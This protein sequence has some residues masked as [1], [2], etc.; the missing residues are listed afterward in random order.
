MTALAARHCQPVH[1]APLAGAA[2]AALLAEVPAWRVVDG[3]LQREFGFDD[4]ARMMGFAN[5]V[6]WLAGRE[7]HHPEIHIAWGRCTVRWSTH[8]VAGLSINDF[9]CAAQVDALLP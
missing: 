5:A 3:A 8:S 6:A 4:Y 1:G 2:L 9:I 7:D